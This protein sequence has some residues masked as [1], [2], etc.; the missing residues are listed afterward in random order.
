MTDYKN[1][2]KIFYDGI[3]IENFCNEKYIKGFTTNPTILNSNNKF[4]NYKEL[5]LY[6]LEKSNNLPVS[7]E[8]FADDEELMIKQGIEINSWGKNIYVKIP[9]INSEGRSTENVIKK[10]NSLG[11]KLNITAIFTEKQSLTAFN[12]ILNK[13]IPTIISIFSGRI[14]DTGIDPKNICINTVNL[15]KNTNIEVLW[16]S[17][18]E[19]F[20]LFNA[21]NCGCHIITVPDDILKKFKYINKDLNQYAIETVKTFYEDGL[22]SKLFIN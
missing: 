4:N 16:A 1:Q 10:L 6:F 18:R 17:T 20:N 2:I 13:K 22:K 11:I 7:F 19:V 12:S 14:A 15:C 8:V 21:I 9:I 3:N 5:A